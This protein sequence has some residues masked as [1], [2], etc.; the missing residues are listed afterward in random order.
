[1]RILGDK[2]LAFT[3]ADKIRRRTAT[4]KEL[5]FDVSPPSTTGDAGDEDVTHIICSGESGFFLFCWRVAL[6][7]CFYWF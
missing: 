2:K 1:M 5:L 7:F 4:S 6:F 3:Q